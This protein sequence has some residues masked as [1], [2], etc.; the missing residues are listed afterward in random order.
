MK[1][2]TEYGTPPTWNFY[3]CYY[4]TLWGELKIKYIRAPED[5]TTAVNCP[6]EMYKI[7]LVEKKGD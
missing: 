2:I 3:K 6:I 5:R 1:V 7:E 4:K